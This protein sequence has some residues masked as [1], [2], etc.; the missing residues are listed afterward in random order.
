VGVDIAS[1][2]DNRVANALLYCSAVL[3][4]LLLLLLL[5]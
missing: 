4:L 2:K 3:L 1:H 5:S